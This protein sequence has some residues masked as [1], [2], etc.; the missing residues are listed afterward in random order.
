MK[1][2]YTFDYFWTK[3][4]QLTNQRKTDK[5]RCNQIWNSIVTLDKRKYLIK[6]VNKKY[7][8]TAKD[9]LIENI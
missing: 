4:H 9:Y 2:I 5:A 7:K 8:R 1:T 6:S 3:F